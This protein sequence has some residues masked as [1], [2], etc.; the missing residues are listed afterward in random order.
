MLAA[1]RSFAIGTGTES[2]LRFPA[3]VVRASTDVPSRVRG[4]T[5]NE[6]IYL[7]EES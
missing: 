5:R 2:L 3:A 4:E 6:S 1:L 7:E